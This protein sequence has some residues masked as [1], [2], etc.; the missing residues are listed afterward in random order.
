MTAL[1]HA[2][3]SRKDDFG[4]QIDQK[5]QKDEQ[6]RVSPGRRNT[7]S[8]TLNPLGKKGAARMPTTHP[9]PEFRI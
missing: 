5:N 1:D 7:R 6:T 4:G 2:I 8:R 3:S 9:N